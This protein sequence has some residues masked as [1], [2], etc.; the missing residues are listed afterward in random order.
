MNRSVGTRHVANKREIRII[1]KHDPAKNFVRTIETKEESFKMSIL[2][3]SVSVDRVDG[4]L[5]K[6][7]F[8]KQNSSTK[9]LAVLLPGAGYPCSGP[10]LYYSTNLLLERKYDVLNVDYDYRFHPPKDKRKDYLYTDIVNSMNSVASNKYSRMVIIA[11]SIGTRGLAYV[12]EENNKN[13]FC[14]DT[15]IIWLTPGWDCDLTYKAMKKSRFP[16]L[17]V[18][19]NLDP[20]YSNEKVAEL[21]TLGNEVLVID[22][23]DHGMDI[24]DSVE[25]SIDCMKTIQKR[26]QTLL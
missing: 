25:D 7:T 5:L 20:F 14:N 15:K 9:D 2:M 11:K 6:N 8:F 1:K 4:S 26:I 12:L 18:I 21:R 19:G 16:G 23:A 3:E 24:V 10:L 13:I 17:F 22:G